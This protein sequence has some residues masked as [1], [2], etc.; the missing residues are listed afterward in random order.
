MTA[1][2]MNEEVFPCPVFEGS[3][4]RISVTF[5]PGP[6]SPDAGLRALL[7]EQLDAMLDLAACQIVSFRS[8]AHF[9]AYVLSESS[10][11][12]YPD[13]I[14]LKTCGTTKLLSCVPVM[15]ELAAGLDMAPSR[16][17]YSRAS[18]LFPEQQPAPHCSFEHECAVLQEAFGRLGR[19]SAYVLGDAL[20]G[21]QWHVFVAGAAWRGG[22]GRGV[23]GAPWALGGLH[24]MPVRVALPFAWLL[25]L[26]CSH[27]QRAHRAPA[28]HPPAQPSQPQSSSPSPAALTSVPLASQ[29]TTH[30]P[31]T[32]TRLPAG[33]DQSGLSPQSSEK[34]IYTLEVCMTG[35]SSR[36]AAQFFRTDDF[37]S[38]QHTTIA[39]GI[40]ALVPGAGAAWRAG[41]EEGRE[42]G[43]GVVVL[44]GPGWLW[45][46][47]GKMPAGL[48]LRFCYCASAGS[49]SMR[50]A[51]RALCRPPFNPF[52]ARPPMLSALRCAAPPLAPLQSSMT[53]CLS[54]AATP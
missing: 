26:V 18:Y 16:V 12:V 5:A 43:I 35:L 22:G 27:L 45:A 53:T 9:D 30:L 38:A 3:E 36:K 40:Q 10:C 54:P 51:L 6:A 17:K 15:L 19:T 50:I 46:V 32:T 14:V 39:S 28:P 24:S 11:F 25:L 4:K 41:G 13:R 47:I 21:L 20:N 42:Q 44:C 48:L 37:V 8:N 29:T 34:P 52:L 2:D 49:C 31:A 7:R 1:A 33:T 23:G